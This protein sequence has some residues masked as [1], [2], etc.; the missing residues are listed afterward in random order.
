MRSRRHAHPC[1]SHRRPP[2]HLSRGGQTVDWPSIARTDGRRGALLAGGVPFIYLEDALLCPPQHTG[3][4]ERRGKDDGSWWT[5][6]TPWACS[7]ASPSK[8]R[9]CRSSRPTSALS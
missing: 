9:P 8:K 3:V 5:G 6:K 7:G 4:V 1:L 2:L